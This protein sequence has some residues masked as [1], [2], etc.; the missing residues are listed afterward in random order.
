MSSWL[1]VFVQVAAKRR[2]VKKAEHTKMI[3]YTGNNR[4]TPGKV[5]HMPVIVANAARC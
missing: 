3:P 1:R 4:R 5:C 2:A